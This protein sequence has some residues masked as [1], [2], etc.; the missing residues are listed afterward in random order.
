MENIKKWNK[1]AILSAIS[2]VLIVVLASWNS[3]FEMDIPFNLARDLDFYAYWHLG[4]WRASGIFFYIPDFILAILFFCTIYF[5][6]KA[7][8]KTKSGLQKGRM[9]AVLTTI[10]SVFVLG[11]IIL[12][13]L[14]L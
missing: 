4:V 9:L 6:A 10:I 11:A 2:L 7:I 3:F 12:S 13:A 14:F 5:G 8:K 1:E